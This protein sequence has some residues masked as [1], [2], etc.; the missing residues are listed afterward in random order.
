MKQVVLHRVLE[1]PTAS[2]LTPL[3]DTTA[4]T[5]LRLWLQD[6]GTLAVT[7]AGETNDSARLIAELYMHPSTNGP[8]GYLIPRDRSLLVDGAT[9]LPV[10][11]VN[12]GSLLAVGR[13]GWL[14]TTRWQAVP[15]PAPAGVAERNCPVCGGPLKLASVVQCLCGRWYHLEKPGA[16]EGEAVLNCLL[17]GPCGLCNREPSLEPVLYPEPPDKLLDVVA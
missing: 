15:G 17:A 1:P 16:A 9:P 8:V 4:G 2:A 7:P 5:P 10:A 11:A 13:A 6:G 14:V 3:P 12:P